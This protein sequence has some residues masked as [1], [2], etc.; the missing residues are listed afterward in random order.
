M[1]TILLAAAAAALLPFAAQAQDTMSAPADS[2]TTTTTT[3]TAPDGSKA[4]G[5]EPYVGVFGGYH[6]FD[7]GDKGVLQLDNSANGAL[8]GGYAGVNIP[9]SF[10]VVGVEGSVAKGFNDIDYEYGATGHVGIR[11]G[12]S[13]MLFAR[14]GYQWINAKNGFRNDRNEIYGFGVEVGPKDIGLGGVTGNAGVRLRLAIDTF[15]DFQSLRPTAGVTFH[16]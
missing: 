10:F 7:R 4:F 2:T 14:A 16:F 12:D 13:G 15:D 11:A 9:L 6:D 1:K 3:A 8:V 5:I